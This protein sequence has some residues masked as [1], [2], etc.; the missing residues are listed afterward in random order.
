MPTFTFSHLRVLDGAPVD[1]P[2][3][4]EVIRVDSSTGSDYVDLIVRAPASTTTEEN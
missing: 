3:G 4:A 2:A 1:L